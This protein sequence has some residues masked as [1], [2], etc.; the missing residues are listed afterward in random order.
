MNIVFHK[1][2]IALAIVAVPAL[3]SAATS[4]ITFQGEVSEQTCQ[5]TMNGDTNSVLLM[6]TISSKELA[7]AGATAGLTPF[8]IQVSGCQVGGSAQNIGTKF[9]GRNVTPAG[10]LGNTGTAKNVAIQLT[11]TSGGD[12]PIALSGPTAVPGLVLNAGETSA[13]YEFGAQYIS[14]GGAAAA[15]SIQA[16]AEYSLSYL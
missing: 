9:L 15:G 12:N 6:P 13:S 16:V 5:A 4:T 7:S 2:L 3:A 8:T 10:N 1:T 14:E 11:A